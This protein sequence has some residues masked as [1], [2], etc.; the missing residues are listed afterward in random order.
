MDGFASN[1]A[2]LR[3]DQIMTTPPVD[4]NDLDVASVRMLVNQRL[5]D[6]ERWNLALVQRD[7]VWDEVRMRHL[8]DSL[9][10]GYPIGAILL[11]TVR[12]GSRE[13][14]LGVDGETR[15]PQDARDG[16]WQVLDGQQRINALFSLLTDQ[17][18]YGRFF[19]NMLMERPE[20][21]PAQGRQQKDRTLPHIRHLADVTEGGGEVLNLDQRERYIDLSRWA[22]WAN[23]HPELRGISVTGLNVREFLRGLDPAFQHELDDAEAELAARNFQRLIH[24]W[25]KPTVPILRAELD[26]PLDVLEVFTR[27]NLGGVQVVGADVYFAGVKTFWDDAERRIDA[28][29]ED[30][31]MLGTRLGALRFLSR[32]AS[33]AVGHGD[34]LPLSIDRLA[35]QRGALLREA[36]EELTAPDSTVRERLASFSR[37][38]LDHSE[39]GYGL[40]RIASELWDDVLAWVASSPRSDD[41]WWQQNTQLIDSYLLGATL[42]RYRAVMGD[43]FR[44]VA[45]LEALDAGSL[46]E[47]FPVEQI[48][49][50]TRGKTKLE[51]GRGRVVRGLVSDEDR[52]AVAG[53]D[54]RL[55]TVLAQRIPYAA[56]GFDWDHIFPQAQAG[57]MW[58]PGQGSR[59]R[60]HPGRKLVNTPGNFWALP[61]YANRAL[62][63]TVGQA[64]FDR[65]EAWMNESE[66]VLVWARDKWSI[67]PEEVANF[68][69]VDQL[70]KDPATIDEGMR[71]FAETV[72]GRTMRLL[73]GALSRFPLVT[74]FASSKDGASVTP[75]TG[76][77]DYRDAL[78]LQVGDPELRAWD[79]RDVKNRL[80]ERAQSLEV[81]LQERLAE[82]KVLAGSRIW[83]YDRRKHGEASHVVLELIGGNCIEL[84]LRWTTDG[85]ARIDVK[86]YPDK[87]RTSGSGLYP[88]F[89]DYP[90][91]VVWTSSDEEVVGSFVAEIQRLED[92]HPR[93]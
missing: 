63:D 50:A 67:K 35:G 30:A 53:V 55:L 86:A 72:T 61:I 68:I 18:R 49:A 74:A 26:S 33:R 1:T 62:Q 82:R 27:I 8:L 14:A 57:R 34:V 80:K 64:K 22:A 5:N 38:F 45:F 59:R 89:V 4:L 81:L 11:T 42:L 3:H 15:V 76:R 77:Y 69:A 48:L 85:G 32:L 91:G 21:T 70:L 78:E 23:R 47:A 66:G 52:T 79:A 36:M 6:S 60:H 41:E 44:R 54:G 10:A 83:T 43:A 7:E 19:L 29:L 51:G 37:W 39:L 71:I 46:A 92:A 31:P 58:I 87:N 20:P 17:G 84:M 56:D 16:A 25:V 88:D 90:L 73:E 28:L 93:G 12:S 9:L 65:L 24:A 2:V 40:H 13:L 75:T